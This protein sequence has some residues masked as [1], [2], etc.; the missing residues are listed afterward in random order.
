MGEAV[1]KWNWK[2]YLSDSFPQ[3]FFLLSS[4]R[5]GFNQAVFTHGEQ[6]QIFRTVMLKVLLLVFAVTAVEMKGIVHVSEVPQSGCL[7]T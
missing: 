4:E 7:Q 6:S 5:S 2:K 1:E 3:N